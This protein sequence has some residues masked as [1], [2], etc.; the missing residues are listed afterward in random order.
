MTKDH[1]EAARASSHLQMRRVDVLVHVRDP[2]L[3]ATEAS[4]AAVRNLGRQLATRVPHRA[5]PGIG[6]TVT[7]VFQ[8]IGSGALREEHRPS[9]LERRPRRIEIDCGAVG[10]VAGI[11]TRIETAVPRP[12]VAVGRI[13]RSMPI[14]PTCTSP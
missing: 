4:R 14:V 9:A 13:V 2:N 8:K 10:S 3:R 1:Q 7:P 11:A 6:C 5:L 12:L